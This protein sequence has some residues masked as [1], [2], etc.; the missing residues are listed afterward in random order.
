MSCLEVKL[1]QVNLKNDKVYVGWVKTLPKPS[2]S[3]YVRLTPLL[4]GY[5]NKTKELIVIID[6]SQI[7]NN[8]LRRGKIK[9]VNDAEMD[10]VIQMN[11]IISASKFDDDLFVR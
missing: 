11:E 7:Y 2:Q 9:H 3:S 8:L 10:L 1:I 6:Y 4:N 5:Q